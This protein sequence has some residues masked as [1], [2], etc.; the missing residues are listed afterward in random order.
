MKLGVI[1]L[2]YWGPNLLRNLLNIPETDVIGCDNNVNRLNLI[3]GKFPNAKY[4]KDYRDLL[5]KDNVDGVL[6]STPLKSHYKLAKIFLEN[7]IDVF[8]EKPMTASVK[9]AEELISLS[10]GKGRILMVGHT[11]V[12]NPAVIKIKDIIDSGEI[13][14]IYYIT[15]TRVNLGIHRRDAN[16][17]WDLA[18]HDFSVIFSW[19]DSKPKYV[20]AVGK[21]AV[22]NGIPDVAFIHTI[23]EDGVIADIQVSWL[24]PSKIR[25]TIIV[26]SKKMIV[27]NDIDPREKVKVYDSG[28]DLK[29][30]YDYGEFLLTYRV[31][32]IRSPK[33]DNREPLKIEVE[34]FLECIKTRSKPASDGYAGLKVVKT[35]EM[36]DKSLVENG[37]VLFF[38]KSI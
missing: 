16:V 23:F 18:P 26:G 11:F 38:K 33:I 5:N 28:V 14:E 17:I 34:H 32:D 19:I 21:D 36:A 30:P 3:K 6:I 15:S 8:V 10:E 7:G 13:G 31:G 24:A 35:L 27:Y 2:G 20:S 4:T 29:E 1:G 25:R 12:F 37:K 9:E 22:L